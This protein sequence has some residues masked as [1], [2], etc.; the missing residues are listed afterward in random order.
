M[1]TRLPVCYPGH[2]KKP[3]RCLAVRLIMVLV[4]IIYDFLYSSLDDHLGALIAGE[5][6]YVNATAFDVCWVL[7]QNG[8]QFGMTNLKDYDMLV[9]II[10]KLFKTFRC[11]RRNKNILS[12]EHFQSP[13]ERKMSQNNW[14]GVLLSH[15]TLNCYIQ[16]VSM[17]YYFNFSRLWKLTLCQRTTFF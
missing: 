8:I 14:K 7:V 2:I 10:I 17:H 16:K 11:W 1:V 6:C 15:R 13:L 12:H 9:L 5:Q 4:G 3:P